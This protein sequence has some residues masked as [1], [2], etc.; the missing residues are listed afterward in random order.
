M[1]HYP[2]LQRYLG[3]SPAHFD[4]I[5]LTMERKSWSFW[6]NDIVASPLADLETGEYIADIDREAFRTAEFDSALDLGFLWGIEYLIGKFRLFLLLA[7]R[8]D[9]SHGRDN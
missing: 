7:S 5:F 9:T 2:D 8:L 3:L 6:L 4:L 1:R